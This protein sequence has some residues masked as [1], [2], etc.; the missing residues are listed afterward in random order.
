MG[1]WL[2]QRGDLAGGLIV[3]FM[4]TA[5]VWGALHYELGTLSEMGPGFF[6]AAIGVLL[7][8]CGLVITVTAKANGGMLTLPDGRG[9]ACIVLGL[10][11]FAVLGTYGGL[12]PATFALVAIAAFGD[13]D[14][15]WPRILALAAA[16]SIIAVVVFWWAL[17]LQLP[18]FAWGS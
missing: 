3:L 2:K 5:T 1:A 9:F 6:P 15:T 12:V 4:G 17:Q 11:A 10:L 8:L 14:N 7:A 13:R 16:M 18:L